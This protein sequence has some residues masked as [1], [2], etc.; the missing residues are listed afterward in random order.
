VV[1]GA[2]DAEDKQTEDSPV[3]GRSWE[4]PSWPS[5]SW[6]SPFP[7]RRRAIGWRGSRAH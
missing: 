7:M 4:P 2:S 5:D 1:Q 6:D 3:E